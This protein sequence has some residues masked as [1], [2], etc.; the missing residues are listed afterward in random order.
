VTQSGLYV[1][2]SKDGATLGNHVLNSSKFNDW[3]HIA[4]SLGVLVGLLVVAYEIRQNTSVAKTEHTRANFDMWISLSSI[5]LESDVG[6][7]IIKSIEEPDNLSTEDRFKLNSWLNAVVS[8]YEYNNQAEQFGVGPSLMDY[9]G[10]DAQY[11][12]ASRYARQWFEDNRRWISAEAA[13]VIAHTIEST[14][15]PS[16]W[17][18]AS[19]VFDD[20]MRNSC[21]LACASGRNQPL[22]C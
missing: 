6:I 12:F 19:G 3:L 20:Q 14:P 15:V 4:A 10:E 9:I 21:M 2:P 7:A 5:E 11:F 16:S 8:I 22:G 1:S 18:E 17:D 13:E